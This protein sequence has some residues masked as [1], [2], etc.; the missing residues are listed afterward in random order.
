MNQSAINV[1]S[2]STMENKTFNEA[3]E[4]IKQN[5]TPVI[6]SEL[7]QEKYG[8]YKYTNVWHWYKNRAEQ[9]GQP[10]PNRGLYFFIST[11][12]EIVYVGRKKRDLIGR[13][14][15]HLG[16][17]KKRGMPFD[18]SDYHVSTMDFAPDIRFEY[19]VIMYERIF[20]SLLRPKYN[21]QCNSDGHQKRNRFIQ[22]K[23]VTIGEIKHIVEHCR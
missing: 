20:I 13:V 19:T 1:P 7:A 5:K 22:D 21:V 17:G 18:A 16:K 4:C 6:W 14:R 15:S 3:V 2:Y 8:K 23:N 11:D 9:A 10:W 12:N